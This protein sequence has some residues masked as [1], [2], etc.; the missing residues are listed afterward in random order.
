MNFNKVITWG[1][2]II[3]TPYILQQIIIL[4]Q[5]PWA[6]KPTYFLLTTGPEFHNLTLL[7]LSFETLVLWFII[8]I[9]DTF[10]RIEAVAIRLF[11]AVCF[12]EL[13]WHFANGIKLGTNYIFTLQWW[14]TASNLI[15]AFPI[16]TALAII[17]LVIHN[18]MNRIKYNNTFQFFIFLI[19]FI[20]SFIIQGMMKLDWSPEAIRFNVPILWAAT[21]F[22][23]YFMWFFI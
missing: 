2:L 19:L 13:I 22:L 16:L 21:K 17:L 20:L 3:L 11:C 6:I 1:L 9:Q 23:G 10:Q 4:V 7:F 12:Y 8:K 18:K 5:D 14:L 15:D